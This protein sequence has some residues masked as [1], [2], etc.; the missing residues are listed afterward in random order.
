M[1]GS[2]ENVFSGAENVVEGYLN[3]IEGKKVMA[4]MVVRDLYNRLLSYYL[5]DLVA[6]NEEIKWEI[7]E[8]LDKLIR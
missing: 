2:C 6:K 4:S 8:E 7:A 1:T 5:S 3:E